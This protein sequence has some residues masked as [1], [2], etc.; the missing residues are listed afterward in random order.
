MQRLVL[1]V[2]LSLVAAL[3]PAQA[4]DPLELRDMGSFHIGG[5]LIEITRRVAGTTTGCTA[6]GATNELVIDSRCGLTPSTV[7]R[8]RSR[9]NARLHT[10]TSM[11]TRG[12]MGKCCGRNPT[13]LPPSLEVM[14]AIGSPASTCSPAC[15]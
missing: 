9:G 15:R 11:P 7:A 6:T 8:A 5:R 3:T 10:S 1:A 13:I 14:I 2:T 12:T 4:K